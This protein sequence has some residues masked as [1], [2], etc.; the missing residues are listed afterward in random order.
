MRRGRP[1]AGRAMSSMTADGP[2]F[3]ID[4]N[5]LVYAYD[6]A[7]SEEQ[8]VARSV[9]ST[10]RLRRAGTLSVQVLGELFNALTR[11]IALPLT[12]QEA[13]ATTTRV[14]RAWPILDIESTTSLEAIRASV[15]YHV[16]YWDGLIWSSAKLAGVPFLLSQD[17]SDGQFIEGVRILNPFK[18]G[19]TLPV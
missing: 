8:D 12:P 2:S 16:S 6:P 10:I 11:K 7:Y 3:F 19:F 18:P 14:A 15:R 9:L 4:T 1:D 13:E 17:L 5:V